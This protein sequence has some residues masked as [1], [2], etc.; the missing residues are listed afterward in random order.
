MVMASFKCQQKRSA[1][2]ALAKLLKFIQRDAQLP[3][4][5]VE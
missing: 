2:L 5:P 3:E 4:N 1:I